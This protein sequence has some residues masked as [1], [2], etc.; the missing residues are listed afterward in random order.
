MMSRTARSQGEIQHHLH[1]RLHLAQMNRH[2]Q[3]DD[4]RPA[5]LAV[6]LAS[7]ASYYD[8]AFATSSCYV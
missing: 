6:S 7:P 2:L 8:A 4:Q 3:F 1:P 5:W